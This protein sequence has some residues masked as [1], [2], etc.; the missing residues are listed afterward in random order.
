MLS[1]LRAHRRLL[2]TVVLSALFAML[3]LVAFLGLQIHTQ[4]P[5]HGGAVLRWAFFLGALAACLGVLRA[6]AWLL[7]SSSVVE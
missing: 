4:G 1:F 6:G 3:G 5:H 7:D 2:V